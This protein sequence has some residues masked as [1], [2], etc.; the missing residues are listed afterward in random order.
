M[1][2]TNSTQ[3]VAVGEV[4]ATKGEVFARSADGHMRRLSIGDQIFEGD[5]I[6]T[7]NGSSAEINMY[8]G[9]ELNVAE[10]QSVAVDSQVISSTHAHD[11]TAGAVT[12]LGSSEAS[13]VI[14]TVNA[15]DQKDFNALLSDQAAAAGLTGGDGGGGST[16]VDLVRIVEIVPTTGFDFPSNS[17]GSGLTGNELLGVPTTQAAVV[18]IAGPGSVIEGDTTTNYTVSLDQVTSS[19]VVVNL[20]YSGVAIDGTDYTG[21]AQVTI[22]AGTSSATFNIAT[23]DD[24]LAE[25]SELFN[26]AIGA[27]SG[28]S[29]SAITVAPAASN[30]NTSIIDEGG[31]GQP[32][33]PTPQTAHV[34]I[35][36]PGSVIEGD[37][38]TNYTVSVDQPTT[39]DLVVNLTY[40]GVAIDGTDYT[41]VAQ[42]TIP[43]GSSSVTFNIA[44]ID[45]NI[46][47]GSE[48]FNVALGTISGGGFELVA[49]DPVANNVNTDIIDEG[50]PGQPPDPTPQTAYVSIVGPGSV[51]EGDTTTNYTVSVDQPT[52]AALTVNLS[53]SGVAIDGTDYTGVAQVTIPSGSTSTTFNIATIDDNIA[54]GSELFNVAISS[55]TGGGFELV[56]ADPVVNNVDT[57]ITDEPQP[58]PHP[59]TAYVSIVGPA[60]VIEGDTTTNYTVSVDQ[61]TTAALTVNLSYSGVAIDGTDYTGVAQVTI[62]SGSTSTTFNIATIDD[63]IAEGSE[64]FNVAISSVTGGGFELVA[65]DPIVNNVDTTITDEPQPDPHPQTAY[66]SIVGPAGVIEGDTTTNYTVSVDQPTTAAL[67][68]N[69]SYS[70]VAIDGTDYTGVAQVTI[71]SGS[72]STTF[73]IATI[74]DNIA[75]G[76]E[77][78]NVA[79]SSVTGGGFELVAADPVVNNVDTTIT[80]EPQPDPHP[81]TAY[82]SIVGPAGVI[83]GD[84]TTNYTVSVDQPTTAA[85]T[86]NL[87]YSGVAI[88]GTDY[89]GVAQVTIPSGST[90]TTF[91]IAT[92]DDNI[93]EGSELFNVAISSVTGGGFEL[94]AAD[95]VVN[96]VDTTI[97]DEPQPD[98][99]P[100]TAYVSIV[101]PGSVVEGDT[102]TNYTVS[103][104]QPTTAA[105][106]VNLSYSGVA[107]DGTDYTGVH[108]VTIPSGSTSTTFNIATILD[109]IIE[110]TE[111]FNVAISSVTGGGFELVAADPVVNNVN[112]N[113]VDQ[114]QLTFNVTG[115]ASVNEGATAHYSV[116][117]SGGTLASGQTASVHVATGPGTTLVPDATS[118]V[119]YNPLTQTLTFTSTD[120]T[121]VGVSVVTLADSIVEGTEEYTVNLSAASSNATIG[122]G[123]VTTNI[124]DQS[125]L[126][127]NVTGDASVNEGATAS[128]TVSYTGGTLAS[129][130]TASVHV[131]TGPGT[132]L[133]PDATSGVDYNPLTQ[134][135]TF[136][137]G[138]AT[139]TNVSVATL[140]DSIVE[141]TE[142]YTV[143]LSAASSNA[144]IG[145]G[146]VTTNIVDQSNL[147]FNITG[148]ASVNEGSTASY[149]VS[150][151]GSLA[152]GQTASVHV[153]TGPGTTLVPD[154]TSG[155]DY[156]PLTQTLTF[157]AG[158]ATSTNV[159]VVTLADSIVE[160]TEEY[161]VNL[162]AASSN[163]TIGTGSV[164]TN[165]VDQS[166]LTFNI[167]GDASVNEGS[168]A[169]YTV[170][171]SGSLANGQTASVHVATGPGTTLVPDATSGVDYNPLTQT[172]TFTAGGATSTNVSVVTLA[173]SI[174]EGTEEYT[175]NL[176]AASANATIGT[177]SVTTNIVDQSNLSFN[178]TG[179]ASVNEG[180]TASYTVSYSGSL[181]SG[182]TASVHVDTGPGTT[183]VPDATSGVDYNPLTQT[184]TFTAAARPAP[185]YRW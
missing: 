80:D 111:V 170:S 181:V 18:S 136:T 21:V 118:G 53:Y 182:Q 152:N 46:A 45:D 65:A 67:T 167:N 137:A 150:Y 59:Q 63:N 132:T 130:Q 36:G 122:T 37:T 24:N 76:S 19:D 8:N 84:T 64:L 50:G 166:N 82:V 22:L 177:G 104:D 183:L 56:A 48:L 103:V 125:H 98:P 14:Q 30:V 117:Y 6:V 44:T 11:A 99:H 123:S 113:I 108:S 164:T 38:T 144:T 54:E 89:T 121:S 115:D 110:G 165:I 79:I 106:T 15:G 168:T 42:V 149:T 131:A 148:D 35:A 96:N 75:E 86:V 163:A 92:I 94:V 71:P 4:V 138:G 52:T 175:V 159:S 27:V 81:Q 41:G 39:A 31:P 157:T 162:S 83:E 32:P 7:A 101:G 29:F 49:A 26:V 147:S 60:G 146:S 151:S 85:L 141:G 28:G 58:D 129:G 179:D 169:S 43:N 176:S 140:A 40:S 97:T 90:S 153:D 135:L 78:F 95:P 25:G 133:V 116:S 119:D 114:G 1:A 5:V 17:T 102:T 70:G 171:Y 88:D 20:T 69:L 13:K 16:F 185:T 62:P 128:Y 91:N 87:S 61:P 66:V 180:A 139:S 109:T 9:P 143:N 10:Q 154:A 156:N 47:E 158:G 120:P 2:D 100:Q 178:I 51:V 77:L 107:I 173:D 184:L 161:T 105:L 126:T 23:I 134:T 93:A 34:S 112:T 73:N 33:D 172:L 72:T 3:A 68:V 55:V 127:F 145:T 160:G 124:V 174:V 155:V 12:E 142:E 74:D 57:T